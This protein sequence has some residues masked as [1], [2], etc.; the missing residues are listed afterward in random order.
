MAAT[1]KVELQYS[2]IAKPP[3]STG[4]PP[5]PSTT[6]TTPSVTVSMDEQQK[7]ESKALQESSYG[8]IPEQSHP[9]GRTSTD[10]SK[11]LPSIAKDPLHLVYKNGNSLNIWCFCFCIQSRLCP[12]FIEKSIYKLKVRNDHLF[13]KKLRFGAIRFVSLTV[14]VWVLI[15][16]FFSSSIFVIIASVSCMMDQ[17]EWNDETFNQTCV[18]QSYLNCSVILIDSSHCTEHKLYHLSEDDHCTKYAINSSHPCW[19]RQCDDNE[20]HLE[21]PSFDEWYC[22]YVP[23]TIGIILLCVG[24]CCIIN[25]KQFCCSQLCGKH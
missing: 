22:G 3:P 17:H 9:V 24:Q 8:N 18:L 2:N 23:L 4:S 10:R 15:S 19:M 1:D 20:V 13:K 16:V 21:Y 7:K 6:N 5:W 11:S 14:L 12:N 25:I